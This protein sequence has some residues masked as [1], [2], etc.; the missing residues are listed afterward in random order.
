MLSRKERARVRA[1]A[2]LQAET[3]PPRDDGNLQKA[4]E[5]AA[6][7]VREAE[8]DGSSHADAHVASAIG[9][10]SQSYYEYLLQRD[11]APLEYGLR[12]QRPDPDSTCPNQSWHEHQ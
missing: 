8:G 3:P 12:F 11:E 9:D 6:A 5:E 2:W 10:L 7:I 4:Q 1:R